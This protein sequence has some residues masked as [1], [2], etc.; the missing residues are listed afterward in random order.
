MTRKNTILFT[1]LIRD[2]EKFLFKL[3]KANDL[4]SRGL[5]SKIVFST[6]LGEIEKYDKV[7]KFIEEAKI[8]TIVSNEP[9]LKLQGHVIHQMKTLSYGLQLCDDDSFVYKMRP[10][11]GDFDDSIIEILKGNYET[12][13][14]S[15]GNWPKF[16]KQ[17][18]VIETAV[19][20]HPFYINDIQ[21]Y[22]QK[23][24]IN[25]L[26]N[27]DLYFEI[28]YS[29][30]AP[31]QFFF[32]KNFHDIEI[33]KEFF[34]INTGLD[35]SDDNNN[36]KNIEILFDSPFYQ[37]IVAIY[38]SILYKYFYFKKTKNDDILTTKN[39]N[40][41]DLTRNKISGFRKLSKKITTPIVN[42]QNFIKTLKTSSSDKMLNLV[43]KFEDISSD[44]Q[45]TYITESDK[46]SLHTFSNKFAKSFNLNSRKDIHN[47]GE[48]QHIVYGHNMRITPTIK[49]NYTEQLES[50]INDMRRKIQEL[51]ANKL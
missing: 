15:S 42:S 6:W 26:I 37:K 35:H 46:E 4:L 17:R 22:G 5:V 49:N 47:K 34:K 41:N 28:H 39:F 3:K 2:E 51:S 1:G 19:L 14:D 50:Q 43:D 40:H 16:F 44:F 48:Y 32:Y 7:Q 31:E 45:Q 11:L 36:I 38:W 8:T 12:E 25:K 33:F 10:D 24:D 21:F 23:T 18:I 30:L 20:Y 13:V 27:F 29:K 9:N